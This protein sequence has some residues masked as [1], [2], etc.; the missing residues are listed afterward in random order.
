MQMKSKSLRA[1]LRRQEL[2]IKTIA[3]WKG[4][5]IFIRPNLDKSWCRH[6]SIAE[7]LLMKFESCLNPRRVYENRE[8]QYACGNLVHSTPLLGHVYSLFWLCMST[9][10]ST[11]SRAGNS[12]V[13]MLTMTA[14]IAKHSVLNSNI[15]L[16][17]CRSC[18]FRKLQ[19]TS[20]YMSLCIVRY[21]YTEQFRGQL[22]EASFVDVKVGGQC[23]LMPTYA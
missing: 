22:W 7:L 6:Q 23:S 10:I 19:S 8:R 9:S 21:Y 14:V 15:W 16:F 13:C 3:R 17:D 2:S 1:A 4:Q 5:E 18:L 11:W 12:L 20:A